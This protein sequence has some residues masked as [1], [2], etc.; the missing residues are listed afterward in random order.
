MLD[1]YQ[2]LVN[3]ISKGERAVLATVITSKGSAPR[4]AGAKMLIRKDGSFVGTVGGGGV[5]QKVKGKAME[6]MNA[7]EPEV[8][9]FDLSGKGRD[10]GMICG[11]QMDVFLEPISTVETLYLFGAGHISRSTAAMG[12]KLGFRVVVIDPR[13]EY[14]NT[15]RFPDADELLVEEYQKAFKKLNVGDDGYIVIYTTGHVSDEECLEFA[16]GTRARYIGMIGS[17]K[18][19]LDVKDRLLKKGISKERL[20]RIYAPIGIEIGA[21]TPEE[22]AISILAEII[23]F[24]RVGEKEKV[25]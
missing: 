1:I 8:L 15:E 3:I 7:I 16:A 11:G 23:R 13:A 17:E 14:N 21:E 12:R 2:A 24:K 5:E 22:I 18:K 6:M 25:A 10:A 19:V 4:K 20:D 9:H